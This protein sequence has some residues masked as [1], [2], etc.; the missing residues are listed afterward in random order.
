MAHAAD[1]RKRPQ[2]HPASS[3]EDIEARSFDI[4]DSEFPQKPFTGRAWEIARRLVHT[5]GD[6]GI[7][8]HLSLP[9]HAIDAG[10]AAIRAGAPVY[11]D[12]E[13]V[14]SGVPLRRVKPFGCNVRCILGTEG[15]AELASSKGITRSR[16]GIE[17]LGTALDG[18]IVAIGNAPTALL[19]LLEAVQDKGVRPALVIGMPV[20]FVNAAESKQMLLDQ[21]ELPSLVVRGR[22]GGSPL[23]AATVNA[24]ALLAAKEL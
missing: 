24:V 14:R 18:A 22:R 16:A 13:M 17:L 2:I 19:A 10:I 7:V 1:A 3:P 12:T 21:G 20:G 4:I 11:T 6:L 23:A 15:I 9:E 5:T 8:E